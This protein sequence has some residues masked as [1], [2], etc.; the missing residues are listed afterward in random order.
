MYD[1]TSEFTPATQVG[2]IFLLFVA[3]ASVECGTRDQNSYSQTM[4]KYN[5]H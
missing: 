2:N 3:Y 1:S 4:S 5:A